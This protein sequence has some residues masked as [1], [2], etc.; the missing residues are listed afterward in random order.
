MKYRQDLIVAVLDLLV[1]SAAGQDPEPEDVTKVDEKIDGAIKELNRGDVIFFT[2]TQQ[3]EDEYVE[4]LALYIAN[5]VA[6][7]FG[8][9]RDETRDASAKARL[10]A[11]R[12]S[13]Y[14]KGSVLAVDYF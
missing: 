10:Y 8:Q 5:I 1:S 13:T 12:P 7:A 11:M 9:P 2:N 6:P 14:V 3:F 4:P